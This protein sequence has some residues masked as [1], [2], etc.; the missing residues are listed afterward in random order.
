MMM[1]SLRGPQLVRTRSQMGGIWI[2]IWTGQH[3]LFVRIQRPTPL[4][5]DLLDQRTQFRPQFE[6]M[7]DEDRMQRR[8]LIGMGRMV[9][10]VAGAARQYGSVGRQN[11]AGIE[12][13]EERVLVPVPKEFQSK[14]LI[15][16]RKQVRNQ[17]LLSS[18]SLN[19]EILSS[20][21][22]KLA[23]LTQRT[24]N[25]RASVCLCVLQKIRAKFL[26]RKHLSCPSPK[27]E[28]LVRNGLARENFSFVV[29]RECAFH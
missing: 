5:M 7:A 6:A 17:I 21:Y 22:W 8:A 25:Y 13:R 10:S 24:Q 4:Y 26:V 20:R 19:F 27:Y 28:A 16:S 9:D 11:C 1:E 29:Y 18:I 23:L 2:G 14:A 12:Q 3:L 15:S